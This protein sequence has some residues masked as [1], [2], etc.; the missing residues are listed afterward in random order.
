LQALSL[1]TGRW[2]MKTE[3][4]SDCWKKMLARVVISREPTFPEEYCSMRI[5]EQQI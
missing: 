2:L 3:T 5:F 4:Y 1:A